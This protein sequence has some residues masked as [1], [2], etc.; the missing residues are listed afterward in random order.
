[1]R[2]I[3]TPDHRLWEQFMNAIQ[4][5]LEAQGCDNC[6]THTRALLEDLPGVDV[7]GS[8]EWLADHGG[9]CCDCEVLM[10]VEFDYDCERKF[11]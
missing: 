6:L 10:N 4:T 2:E 8:L 1:M 9:C 3:M 11:S 7:D 5:L